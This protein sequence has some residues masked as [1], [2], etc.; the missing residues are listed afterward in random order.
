[1]R[2]GTARG[3][4]AL[5][6]ALGQFEFTGVGPMGGSILGFP[7]ITSNSVPAGY[8]ILVKADEILLADDGNVQLDSS[9]E[10]TLDMNGGTS[11]T[12]NL[13]QRNCIGIRAERGITWVKRRA[14]AIAVITGAD[15]GPTAS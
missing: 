2:P 1:M 9:R 10:A 7:V 4:S 15:Y 13:W 11:P 12:F 8:V 3:I 6:N 14:D 5:R